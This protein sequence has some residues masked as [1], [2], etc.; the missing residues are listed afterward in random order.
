MSRESM[1]KWRE[2]NRAAYNAYMREYHR[3]YYEKNRE[4]L[5]E[6][7]RARNKKYRETHKEQIAAYRRAAYKSSR[8][9]QL[10]EAHACARPVSNDWICSAP[11]KPAGVSDVRWRIELRR[12]A[13]PG[14]Y[15]ICGQP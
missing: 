12:R 15:A 13:N 7:A 9:K 10:A 4:K 11:E 2:A 3:A 1:K 5:N 6:A 14:Y 8:E